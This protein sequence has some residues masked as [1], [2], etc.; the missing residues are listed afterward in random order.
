MNY[1]DLPSNVQ[2]YLASRFESY[3]LDPALA[4]DSLLPLEIKSQGAEAI[5]EFMRNKHISHI[6]PQSN[7]PEMADSLS[8]I[9]LEDPS[10]NLSRGNQIAT[11]DE[12]LTARIDNVSDSF[13]GDFNDDGILDSF[14]HLFGV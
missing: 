7:Y 9:F 1:Y 8:N 12:I 6:Y 14:N 13:D 11:H 2:S 10:V 4:Y 5:E 3:G